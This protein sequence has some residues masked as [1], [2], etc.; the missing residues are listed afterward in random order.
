MPLVPLAPLDAENMPAPPALP[1]GLRAAVLTADESDSRWEGGFGY[2]TQQVD[3]GIRDTRLDDATHQ[4]AEQFTDD[5][6]AGGAG[7]TDS[8]APWDIYAPLH[9]RRLNMDQ[10]EYVTLSRWAY[11]VV[12]GHQLELG[13]A[14]GSGADQNYRLE[15]AAAGLAPVA[16]PGGM[17]KGTVLSTASTAARVIGALDAAL[18][19]FAGSAG[20]IHVPATAGPAFTAYCTREGSGENQRWVTPAGHRLV[21]GSGYRGF[22]V[23]GATPAANTTWVY[24]TPQLAYRSTEIQTD[25]ATVDEARRYASRKNWMEW[26]AFRTVALTPVVAAGPFAALYDLTTG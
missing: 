5:G 10:D 22:S 24:A 7:V 23:N 3:G 25:P 17:V 20:L 13:L 16:N 26:R 19:E 12:E 8:Y 14:M 2:L 6:E 11:S 9:T 1:G 21:V 18:G 4:A 15:D